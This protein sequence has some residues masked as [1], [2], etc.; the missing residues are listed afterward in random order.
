MNVCKQ[1]FD[2]R[3]GRYLFICRL[4][5]IFLHE[6]SAPCLRSLGNQELQLNRCLFT[7]HYGSS[8]G[9]SCEDNAVFW[10]ELTILKEMISGRRERSKLSGGVGLTKLDFQPRAVVI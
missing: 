5:R 9:S 2:S 6:S 7:C 10:N 4:K 8:S 1:P 3:G